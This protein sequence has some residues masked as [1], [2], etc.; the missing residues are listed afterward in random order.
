MEREIRFNA[1]IP[2]LGIMIEDVVVGHGNIGFGSDNE[3]VGLALNA[4]GYS[5][6]DCN[7]PAEWYDTGEDWYHV[8]NGFE[9]VQF[10][11]LKDKNKVD[12]FEGDVLSH[13]SDGICSVIYCA[14][15]ASFKRQFND[16]A[17]P[18]NPSEKLQL[19]FYGRTHLNC[20]V[21]GNIFENPEL[22][23]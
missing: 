22:I 8:M 18:D 9:L 19:L 21:I 7:L 20:E 16:D 15:Y 12:I 11:G 23:A 6:E 14:E 2:E 3:D 10:T 17:N 13:S 5:S 4:K 1:W